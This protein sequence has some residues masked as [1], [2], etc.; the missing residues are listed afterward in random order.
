MAQKLAWRKNNIREIK[1]TW[2]RFLAII[3]IIALGTGFYSGLKITKSAMVV[4][5]DSYI[6]KQNMYDF[7]L[8][9]TLGLTKEDVQHF[10]D[11]DNITAEGAISVDFIAA[12]DEDTEYVLKAHSITSSINKLYLRHGRLP[13]TANECVLD[14]RMFSEDII[15]SIIKLASS[16]DE[17]T[18][19]TFAYDEYKVVGI[20]NSVNYLN[21]DRGT[22]KLSG[23]S[24]HAFVYIPIEGFSMDY[25]TEILIDLENDSKAYSED[26]DKLISDNKNIIETGLKERADLRHKEIVDEAKEKLADAQKKYDEGLQEYLTAK[27]DADKELAKAEA[28]L[29]DARQKLIDSEAEL[30]DGERK[31]AEAEEEYNKSLKEYEDALKKYEK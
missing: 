19:D 23:G 27:A 18:Q 15:G 26:Y 28:D 24:V 31:L 17:D 16:N 13:E 9:S 12:F 6:R 25:F 20:V 10:S 22:T 30:K 29:E 11:M 3:A 14:N 8:L 5:M 4:S 2:E 1:H 7:R 21:Y